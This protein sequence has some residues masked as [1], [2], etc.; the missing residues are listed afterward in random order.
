MERGIIKLEIASKFG[1]FG[2][3]S[4]KTGKL[5]STYQDCT[6]TWTVP[7]SIR[8]GL[9][10][11]GLTKKDE[12]YFENKLGYPEG[13]LKN[14]SSFWDSF[15]I[16]I[17]AQ[18]VTLDLSDDLSFLKYHCLKADPLIATS[19]EEMK[20]NPYCQ[21]VMIREA[22]KAENES[23]SRGI[24]IKA[25]GILNTLTSQ[26]YFDLFLMIKNSDPSDVELSIVK[27]EVEKYAEKMPIQFVNLFADN[28]FKDK[29]VLT[30]LIGK[31]IINKKGRG[32]N[33]PLYF[34]DV[35]LGN[36]IEECMDFLKKPINNSIFIEI[37][38]KDQEIKSEQNSSISL[39]DQISSFD[40]AKIERDENGFAKE[41][42]EAAS[43][44]QEVEVET[45]VV[46][47]PKKRVKKTN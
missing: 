6:D 27:N 23:S 29:V 47:T 42:A 31:R 13:H 26:D 44:V 4:K 28:N 45:E 9:L 24:K 1:N 37:M 12:E 32:L 30:K 22:E 11:T 2:A 41:T 10:I 43:L 17:P 36:N 35:F 39:S 18:G 3:K 25:Y 15:K 20:N 33:S 5:L 14:T 46:Q 38:R 7:G 21:Y 40:A 8:T 16:K 19:N 34:N